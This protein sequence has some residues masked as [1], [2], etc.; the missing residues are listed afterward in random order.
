MELMHIKWPHVGVTMASSSHSRSHSH[1]HSRNKH[2]NEIEYPYAC[3]GVLA[4]WSC[5]R[6]TAKARP[7]A[8]RP[9]DIGEHNVIRGLMMHLLAYMAYEQS[10]D[11]NASTRLQHQLEFR[12]KCQWHK[13][14]YAFLKRKFSYEM[15]ES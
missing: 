8:D 13:K 10:T 12:I 7:H 6:A 4:L 2:K 15:S 9:L 1:S 3:V 5:N 11:V 14:K